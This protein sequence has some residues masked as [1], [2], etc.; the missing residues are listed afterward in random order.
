MDFII[1]RGTTIEAGGTNPVK[2]AAAM[3]R[4]DISR[5]FN[6]DV[7]E[8]NEIAYEYDGSM[9]DED[10]VVISGKKLIVKAGSDLGF[11]YGLIY[12]S[13]EFLGVKP[14][15]FWMDTMPEK[16]ASKA[17]PYGE[18]RGRKPVVKYRGWFV[19]DEV[20]IMKWNIGGEWYL[21]RFCA[22]AEIR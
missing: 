4:R 19:N 22:A 6:G 13:S 8:R 3:L 11:V 18:Y 15:W 14:F 1:N 21:K 20:L 5:V 2:N 7:I 16:M 10:F 12:I 9:E 17:V